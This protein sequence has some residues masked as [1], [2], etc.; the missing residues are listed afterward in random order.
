MWGLVAVESNSQ[1]HI[2]ESPGTG[3][4]WNDGK[5]KE[6]VCAEPFSGHAVEVVDFSGMM[7]ACLKTG[8]DSHANILSAFITFS[9]ALKS[10]QTQEGGIITPWSASKQKAELYPSIIVSAFASG[11]LILQKLSMDYWR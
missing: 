10:A 1:L 8:D 3:K 7:L 9:L 2:W 6:T 5:R 11:D 4:R